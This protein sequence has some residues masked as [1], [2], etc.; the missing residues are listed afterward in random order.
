M[1]YCF[2]LPSENLFCKK[3]EWIAFFIL[4]RLVSSLLFV[5]CIIVYQHDPVYR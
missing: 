4:N 2:Y 1:M 3:D 5:Y